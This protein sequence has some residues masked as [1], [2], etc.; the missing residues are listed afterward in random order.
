MIAPGTTG[1]IGTLTFGGNVILASGTQ[2]LIDVGPGGTS[3]KIAV[4]ANNG[5]GGQLNVG[6][7]VGFAPVSGQVIRAGDVYTIATATGGISGQFNSPAAL[8]A[9]LTPTLAYSANAITARIVAAPM[10]MSSPP[11]VP[12][13]LCPAARPESQQPG[14]SLEPVR[15][16]RPGLGRV[17]PHLVGGAGPST[18]ALKR[19]QG[20]M[21]LD[22]TARFY[23]HLATLS[24]RE[25]LG[26]TLTMVGQPVQVA[27]LA[28]SNLAGTQAQMATDS[29]GVS[30]RENVLPENVAVFLAGD[31][32]GRSRALPQTTSSNVRD[33]FDGFYVA[34][35]IETEVDE[36]SIIGFGFSY[37]KTTGNTSFGQY[38]RGD[39]YQGTLYGKTELGASRWTASSARA[40]SRPT[41]RWRG[42]PMTCGRATMPLRCRARSGW[43]RPIASAG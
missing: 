32:I 9:I 33:R 37:T 3:D 22:N 42:S 36:A 40:C 19:G 18:E 7:S 31:T 4:V 41:S 39:L 43:P 23:E 13:R 12:D 29:G 20:T 35:G 28:M 17:D 30:M 10:P 24:P 26:G 8:S 2:L 21:A 1:T 14:Q 34:T 27:S 16:A 6:G 25:G 15:H 11:R 38:A 5:S